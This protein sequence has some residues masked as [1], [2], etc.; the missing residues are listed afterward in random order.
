MSEQKKNS[1][2]YVE[3]LVKAYRS[4]SQKAAKD[5]RDE[6]RTMLAAVQGLC[7]T[8]EPGVHL[9]LDREE[10]VAV[11]L[12]RGAMNLYNLA[13]CPEDEINLGNE[14]EER[15]RPEDLKEEADYLMEAAIAVSMTHSLG[16]F[17]RSKLADGETDSE[18]K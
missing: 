7:E 2:V 17:W 12:L 16:C 5:S 18:A 3:E 1:G 10:E 15:I 4:M 13:H 9:V 11:G 14:G 8:F 6:Q